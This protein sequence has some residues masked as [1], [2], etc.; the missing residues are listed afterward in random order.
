MMCCRHQKI[1]DKVFLN[2]LHALDASAAAVL[3]LKVIDGHSLDITKV[4]HGDDRI[5]SRDHILHGNIKFIIADLTSSVVAVFVLDHKQLAA[6]NT[7][8]TLLVRQNCL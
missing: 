6:D 1:C 7:Q 5:L 2:R 4:R 8:Q 3:R